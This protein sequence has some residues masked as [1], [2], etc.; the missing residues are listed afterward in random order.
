MNSINTSY[1]PANTPTTS[2]IATADLEEAQVTPEPL[3]RPKRG[4]GATHRRWPQHSTVSIAFQGINKEQ[5]ALVQTAFSKITPHVNLKFKYVPGPDADIRV[6]P[7]V[8]KGQNG[9][10]YVGTDAKRAP[11]T[12]PTLFM[13][14]N[15]KPEQVIA[16]ALHEGLHAIGLIHEHQHPD[17]TIQFDEQEILPRF[18][19]SDNPQ[20]SMKADILDKIKR[21]KNGPLFTT[22]DPKS[23]MHYEFT[24][25]ELKGSPAI[26]KN[27]ELSA[28]DIATL[29]SMYP[30]RPLPRLEDSLNQLQAT[31]ATAK[32][33][34]DLSTV[35]VSLFGMTQEQKKFVTHNIE[36]LQPY[37]NNHI[38][39]IEQ[40]TGDIRISLNNEGKSWSE[41]GTDAKNV[42]LSDPTMGIHWDA[43][44]K[45]TARTIKNLFA[46]AVGFT[47]I[48]LPKKSA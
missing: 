8:V 33:W 44:K 40:A 15:R 21:Q 14:F 26:I 46:K 32:L 35:T 39:F 13:D 22:Y 2:P 1:P 19:D 3:S 5:E 25:D 48:T 16:T 36:K 9:S 31:A 45:K 47:N 24:S 18:K 41:I 27:N 7:S 28:G 17:R 38:E 34:P 30:P 43:N 11:A 37:I 29:K 10:S 23:I 4:I 12:A 20:K 42:K 6:G